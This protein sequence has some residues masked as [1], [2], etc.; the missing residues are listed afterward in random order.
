MRCS[1]WRN[2]SRS[3]RTSSSPVGSGS[4][5]AVRP[6]LAGVE[7]GH[8]HR[9]GVPLPCRGRCCASTATRCGVPLNATGT[10]ADSCGARTFERPLQQRMQ[11][12]AEF[13]PHE[14]REPAGQRAAACWKNR[15][16]DGDTCS[17]F[18]RSSTTTDGGATCSE[19]G[20]VD[21]GRR[22]PAH[23][24]MSR[25]RPIPR[26]RGSVRM[27][28]SGGRAPSSRGRSAE[29]A[30]LLVDGMERDPRPPI[31]TAP[32]NSVRVVPAGIAEHAHDLLLQLP[33]EIDQEVAAGDQMQLRENGGS[34]SRL[35][36]AKTRWSRT[37]LATR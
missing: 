21:L 19:R 6:W 15:D 18:Q 3:E 1:A 20:R 36:A 5:A 27:S 32:R 11:L 26:R 25:P 9:R 14:I 31:P 30:V 22:S 10:N 4:G 35:C 16:A 34:R 8:Q 37:S 2:F 13:R 28:G 12:V 7:E 24:R 23:G 17:T 29:N 33:I